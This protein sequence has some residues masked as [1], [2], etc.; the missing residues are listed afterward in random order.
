LH[1]IDVPTK[2]TGVLLPCTTWYANVSP[3][4][5]DTACNVDVSLQV[6]EVV[7]EVEL[8]KL[9]DSEVEDPFL[10][11]VTVTDVLV[12]VPVFAM[13]ATRRFCNEHDVGA[14]TIED[15]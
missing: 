1:C 8:V 13:V 3:G 7:V 5:T 12:E 4:A 9:Q 6:V 15:P 14:G 11:S 2:K 10:K